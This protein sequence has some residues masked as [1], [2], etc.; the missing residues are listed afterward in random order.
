MAQREEGNHMKNQNFETLTARYEENISLAA[1]WLE[2][3]G[4]I[5]DDAALYRLGVV[6]DDSPE[7]GPYKGRLSIPYLTPNGVVDIRFRS[8]LPL[9]PKYLS[10]PGAAPHLY[11][12]PALWRDSKQI[13]ICEGEIDAIVMDLYSGIPAVGV[14]GVQLWKDHFRRVFA[15]YDRVL[16]IGDGDDAG[17]EFA[18]RIAGTMDNA[19]AVKMRDGMDVNDLL[20]YEGITAVK[21]LVA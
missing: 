17:R 8:M 7:S 9:G 4:L 11:N 18:N 13:A 3:R 2:G 15:D 16:I 12:V 1:D 5:V 20:L 10:R 21:G 6:N 14:P 19:V